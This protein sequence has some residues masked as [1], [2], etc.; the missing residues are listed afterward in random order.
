[1]KEYKLHFI[2]ASDVTDDFYIILDEVIDDE[3]AIRESEI[4][5]NFMSSEGGIAYDEKWN[6]FKA[7]LL[8]G[9]EPIWEDSIIF[10]W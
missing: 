1:M 3:E 6:G 7:R 4:Q 5:F 10:E 2:N 8:K 9:G